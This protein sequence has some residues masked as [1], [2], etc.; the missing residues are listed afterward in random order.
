MQYICMIV[1]VWLISGAHGGNRRQVLSLISA[2]HGVR[3]H[4]PV[5]SIA[6]S[7]LFILSFVI[8]SVWGQQVTF[9]ETGSESQIS[10]TQVFL[11]SLIYIALAPL[12]E[13][14]I[15]RGFLLSA[16]QKSS[17]GYW[18]ASL[19]VN[20]LWTSLHLQMPGYAIA[21]TFVAGLTFSVALWITGSLWTCIIAHSAFNAFSV[22]L[23]IAILIA[24]SYGRGVG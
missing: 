13:E 7:V 19:L 4:V 3:T 6:L 18:G 11:Q 8:R 2:E 15:F 20:L 24:S 9:A 12:A 10:I 16:L 14:L 1:L 22:A 5:A 17:L 21:T 23:Y